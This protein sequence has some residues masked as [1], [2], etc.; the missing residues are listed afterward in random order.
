MVL[1]A[2]EVR[3]RI[4]VNRRYGEFKT[5]VMRTF[6][7]GREYLAEKN[8][9]VVAFCMLLGMNYFVDARTEGL[10]SGLKFVGH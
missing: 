9:D 7:T 6:N 10:A 8:H 3:V 5:D 2:R 4:D 1:D